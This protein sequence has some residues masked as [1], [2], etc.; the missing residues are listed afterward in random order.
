MVHILQGED[1]ISY[2]DPYTI[3]N[4]TAATAVPAAFL[5]TVA[6]DLE[7]FANDRPRAR[8]YTSGGFSHNS[9]GNL[10]AVT[11]DTE[12]YDVGGCHSTSSNT[13]RLTVPSG[14][15]GL[16]HIGGWG[17]WDSNTAGV[18]ELSISLNGIATFIA[19]CRIDAD[20]GNTMLNVSCDYQLAVGDYVQLAAYQDSGGTRTLNPSEF[21]FRWVANTA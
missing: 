10:L 16:Y 8:V 20:E 6:D 2:V 12:R 3:Y 4:P 15:A 5:D 21:W 19:R 18:R 7:W 17:Q 1:A 11:Y 14:G 9:T 13:S